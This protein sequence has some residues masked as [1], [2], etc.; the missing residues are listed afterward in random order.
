MKKEI[1]FHLDEEVAN[2][3]DAMCNY[4]YEGNC[5]DNIRLNE[6]IQNL[7]YMLV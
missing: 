2:Q 5:F 4:V 7:Q 1:H 3:I 6:F